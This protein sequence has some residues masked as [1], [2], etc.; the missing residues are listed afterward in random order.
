MKRTI[1]RI[2]AAAILT[3]AADASALGDLDLPPPDC[4]APPTLAQCQ[5]ASYYTSYCGQQW[6]GDRAI[7]PDTPCNVLLR[8]Y[9]AAQ[10][11]V[12]PEIAALSADITDTAGTVTPGGAVVNVIQGGSA[13]GAVGFNG[14]TSTVYGPIL[15]LHTSGAALKTDTTKAAT[16]G[17]GGNPD[18]VTSCEDYALGLFNAYTTFD[19]RAVA[20]DEDFRAIVD[21]A[22]DPADP[23]AIGRR[24]INGEVLLDEIGRPMANAWPAGMQPKNAF[25]T[26]PVFDGVRPAIP[27]APHLDPGDGR[28]DRLRGVKLDAALAAKVAGGDADHVEGWAWH[29]AM[30]DALSPA[31]IDEQLEHLERKAMNFEEQLALR[32]DMVERAKQELVVQHQKIQREEM[33]ECLD[34]YPPPGDGPNF[35]YEEYFADMMAACGPDGLSVVAA[36]RQ[37]MN[38]VRNAI[39]VRFSQF[40]AKL[41]AA[42]Q[43][44]DADGCLVANGASPCD[45]SPS[46]FYRRVNATFGGARE[47]ANQWCVDFTRDDFVS[48]QNHTF[49][50]PLTGAIVAS[51]NFT[52]DLATVE[53][54]VNYSQQLREI[55]VDGVDGATLDPAGPSGPEIKGGTSDGASI[56]NDLFSVGY[57]YDMSWRAYDIN[58]AALCNLNAEFDASFAASIEVYGRSRDLISAA[59]R[60]SSTPPA[61]G[62]AGSLMYADVDLTVF[63]NEIV[64]YSETFGSETYDFVDDNVEQSGDVIGPISAPPIVILGLPVTI[65]VGATGTVGADYMAAGRIERGNQNACDRVEAAIEGSL[66]PYA[67][68]DA[69]AEA[70]VDAIIAALGIKGEVALIHARLPFTL[71]FGVGA[72]Q[73]ALQDLEL[74]VKAKL[75]AALRT[76][77]GKLSLFGRLGVCPVCREAERTIFKWSGLERTWNVLDQSFEVNLFALAG[78][79]ANPF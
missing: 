15:T 48:M 69:Y 64:D 21:L 59:A 5:T 12:L 41:I 44:A 33:A 43:A 39:D 76:L 29:K 2:T 10:F 52:T 4:S 78:W 49:H 19:A 51:G 27:G 14:Q 7:D 28:L 62:A 77:D 40:D 26:V 66:A 50:H 3:V 9:F 30:N 54:Y 23:D 45:W 1:S 6:E 55:L 35:P 70:G 71:S 32:G 34:N 58:Q 24:A 18:P 20:L 42:L 61:G 31:F 11:A 22:F 75:D 38:P 67:N 16:G 60:V 37:R 25:F 74:F 73:G 8:D 57:A 46:K 63:G 47:E 13:A 79:F 68:V 72:D 53:S 17:G 36:V 56:G 65:T